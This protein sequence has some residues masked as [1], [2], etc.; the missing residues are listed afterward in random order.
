MAASHA[1]PSTF[2]TSMPSALPM[3]SP[4]AETSGSAACD[5]VAAGSAR[6]EPAKNPLASPDALVACSRKNRA[7]GV[8][9][10]TNQ[11]VADIE[12]NGLQAPCQFSRHFAFDF[13]DATPW[14]EE[15]KRLFI[16]GPLV[17]HMLHQH[18]ASG[19]RWTAAATGA[20]WPVR[21]LK[22]QGA[23]L[24]IGPLLFGWRAIADEAGH[25]SLSIPVPKGRSTRLP[26]VIA[27]QPDG[28]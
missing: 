12:R 10:D 23:D 3:F 21:A 13:A 1:A 28:P 7:N 20:A 9:I 24:S 26:G 25:W 5:C 17:S 18:V 11:E 16:L 8:Q 19:S 4:G 2:S 15:V 27:E 14:I 6:P 22:M